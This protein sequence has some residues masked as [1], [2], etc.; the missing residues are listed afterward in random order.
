[1]ANQSAKNIVKFLRDRGYVCETR[2]D[3]E[4]TASEVRTCVD[5]TEHSLCFVRDIDYLDDQRTLKVRGIV[6]AP[7]ELSEELAYTYADVTWI[8]TAFPEAAFY[9]LLRWTRLDEDQS[10]I[11]QTAVIHPSAQLGNHVS[12]G[13]LS[14]IGP[15]VVVGDR[16]RIGTNCSLRHSILGDAVVLQDGV[17]L[18]GEALG[19]VKKPDG[20]WINRPGLCGVRIDSGTRVED[21][22]VIHRGFLSDTH[23]HEDVQIGSNCCIG[24]GVI[25]RRGSLIAHGVVVAGSVQIGEDCTVWGRV[26]IREGSQIESGVTIGMGS[27]VLSNLAGGATYVGTPARQVR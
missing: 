17:M 25:V 10:E 7:N 11:H 1:M 15:D 5:S 4:L 24:N 3:L 27:V 23:I 18:G 22:T 2:G 20:T 21:N 26:A 9:E 16:V 6:I 14:Y 12:I 19:A 8:L 13:P